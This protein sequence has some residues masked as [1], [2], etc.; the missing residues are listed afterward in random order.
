MLAPRRHRQYPRYRVG[1]SRTM[2]RDNVTTLQRDNVPTEGRQ[3]TTLHGP[4]R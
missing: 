2:Q 3:T 1:R 4:V